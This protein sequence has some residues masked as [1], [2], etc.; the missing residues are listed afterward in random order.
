M[1]E[2]INEDCLTVLKDWAASTADISRARI[3]YCAERAGRLF[4]MI[5]GGIK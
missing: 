3:L 2:V 1:F 4:E 5:E